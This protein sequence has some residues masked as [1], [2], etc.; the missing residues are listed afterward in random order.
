MTPIRCTL[1]GNDRPGRG[2]DRGEA[3]EAGVRQ[4]FVVV[5]LG[6]KTTAWRVEVIRALI[7]RLGR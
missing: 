7:E 4:G 1:I 6:V 5:K 3:H 2:Y